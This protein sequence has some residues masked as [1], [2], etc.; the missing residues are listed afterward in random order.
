MLAKN[1]LTLRIDISML[2]NYILKPGLF[3]L[4]VTET[5]LKSITEKQEY[6]D[7]DFNCRKLFLMFTVR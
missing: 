3:W 4:W 6:K 5:D 2:N 1:M 7:M